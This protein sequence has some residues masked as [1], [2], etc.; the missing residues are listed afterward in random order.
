MELAYPEGLDAI[1]ASKRPYCDIPT[2]AR[3]EDYL[4]PE[5]IA[6]T[7]CQDLA[8]TKAGVRGYA[9]RLG[10]TGHPHL[11]LLVQ[12]CD[13]HDHDVWVFSVDTHDRFLQATHELDS[14]EA[15]QWR[16]LYD[17]NAK[18]KAQIESALSLAGFMTPT[19]LLRVD[20]TSSTSHA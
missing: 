1:P 20:L 7:V 19:G 9:F 16:A 4:P 18:L 3:V 15:R 13:L 17:R 12:A 6:A 2:D 10:S 5:P 11:K 14:E 8:K